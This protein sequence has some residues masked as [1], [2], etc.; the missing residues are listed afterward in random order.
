MLF[1]RRAALQFNETLLQHLDFVLP[2]QSLLAQPFIH[3]FLQVERAAMKR[4]Q[5]CVAALHL[6]LERGLQRAT[7]GEAVEERFKE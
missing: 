3:Q 4:V 6:I 7:V 5:K 1:T 2:V